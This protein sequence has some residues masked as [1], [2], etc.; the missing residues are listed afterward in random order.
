M[1]TVNRKGLNCTREY[2]ENKEGIRK[3][4][5]KNDPSKLINVSR[6]KRAE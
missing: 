1:G 4:T 3:R 5:R 6:L 2:T